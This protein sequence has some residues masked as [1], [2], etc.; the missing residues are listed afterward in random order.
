MTFEIHII[1]F[2]FAHQQWDDELAYLAYLNSKRCWAEIG[3]DRCRKTNMFP[4]AGQNI[5]GSSIK[6]T[7]TYDKVN[8]VIV[9]QTKS[10]FSENKHTSPDVIKAYH[11]TGDP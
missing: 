9:S 6:G 10:W 5:A 3:H 4:S 7:N 11:T 8:D 1:V 2:F